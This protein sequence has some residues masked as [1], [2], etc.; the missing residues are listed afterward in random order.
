LAGRVFGVDPRKKLH[1][2]NL[3]ANSLRASALSLKPRDW[4]QAGNLPDEIM[5][6]TTSW[7]CPLRAS[8]LL[9]AFSPPAGEGRGQTMRVLH[10]CEDRGI[11]AVFVPGQTYPRASFNGRATG[12][13]SSGE[14]TTVAVPANLNIRSAIAEDNAWARLPYSLSGYT[15]QMRRCAICGSG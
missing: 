2:L 5:A 15:L 7:P 9:S 3:L 10:H 4:H 14:V 13:P 8:S 1:W 6:L 12:Y 11:I